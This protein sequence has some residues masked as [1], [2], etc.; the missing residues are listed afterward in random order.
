MLILEKV[1]EVLLLFSKL[2][3]SMTKN[4]KCKQRIQDKFFNFSIRFDQNFK[5]E[6]VEKLLFIVFKSNVILIDS[7]IN[8]EYNRHPKTFLN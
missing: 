4:S 1:S 8:A 7:N 6:N 2:K 3:Y 5:R